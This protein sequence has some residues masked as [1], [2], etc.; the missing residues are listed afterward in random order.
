[1]CQ[2]D[3]L[4][5]EDNCHGSYIA[6]TT[7]SVPRKWMKQKKRTE[8]IK[9][10][11]DAKRQLM[12]NN[13]FLQA[14]LNRQALEKAMHDIDDIEDN[15]LSY[16]DSS[17]STAVNP[18]NSKLLK[19]D[20]AMFPQVRIREVANTVFGQQWQVSKTNSDD[21]DIGEFDDGD[22]V[23]DDYDDKLDN[24]GEK[25]KRSSK[26]R[27]YVMPSRRC[28]ANWLE[29]ASFLNLQMVAQSLIEKDDNVVTI[30][31]DDTTK[32][33]VHKVIDVKNDHITICRPTGKKTMTTGYIENVSH[34]GKDA[35]KA[36]EYKLQ[37]LAILADTS[38]DDIKQHID[39]WM[40]DRAADCSK[41][42]ECM[43]V[44]S[45]KILKC[46]AHVI[47]GVDSAIDKVF[48]D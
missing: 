47:L 14:D 39:F 21:Q 9:K 10:A 43:E 19:N 22:D 36:Y 12:M 25:R 38:L 23:D 26:D 16:K 28:L 37:S 41:M 45:D 29:A 7:P 11:E 44:Q 34:T 18:A 31:L 40:T 15:D 30:G 35:A 1:M 46:C 17:K 6:R 27:T 4:F 20:P 2:D 33:A 5:Y 24:P 32:A 42:L 3:H 13:T 48:R 8:E